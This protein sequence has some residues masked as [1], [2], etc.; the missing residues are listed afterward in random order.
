MGLWP[1]LMRK[2]MVIPGGCRCV[3]EGHCGGQGSE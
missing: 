3:P 2:R 1:G